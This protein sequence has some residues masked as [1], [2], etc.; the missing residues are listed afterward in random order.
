MNNTEKK[1]SLVFTG[2]STA[3]GFASKTL[4]TENSV[5][6]GPII[7]E[8]IQNS[9]DAGQLT[10]Q[11]QVRV[12]FVFEELATKDLPGIEEY[13]KAFDA[14]LK[15]HEGHIENAQAQISR[16]KKSLQ[17]QTV[18]I[19]NVFDNGIG[20]DTARMNSLLG[21]GTTSKSEQESA[22]S[23]GLGHFTAFPASNL[24]F[25]LYGGVTGNSKRT[26]SAHVILASHKIN[27]DLKGKDGF[28][29]KDTLQTVR[30]R[31]VFPSNGEI[32]AFL[33]SQ[34]DII[35]KD[36]DSGS[37]VVITAFNDF[38]EA[39][40]D[41]CVE[42][43]LSTAAKHFFPSI[44]SGRLVVSVSRKSGTRVLDKSSLGDIISKNIKNTRTGDPLSNSKA[45][46]AYQTLVLSDERVVETSY[47]SVIIHIRQSTQ[48]RTRINLFRSGMWIT[49][50]LPRNRQS[51]YSGYKPFNALV[52]I[53]PP[54]EAF[55]LVRK[56][57]GEKHL[58]ISVKRLTDEDGK[59]FNV[60]FEEIRS[61]IIEGLEKSEAQVYSPADFMLINPVG[62]GVRSSKRKKSYQ[63]DQD[64][65]SIPLV[66]EVDE[67]TSS[68]H[69]SESPGEYQP[70]GGNET[71]TDKNRVP[72]DEPGRTPSF[73]RSG[74]DADVLTVAR[75][76]G[77]RVTLAIRSNED[78]TNA[79]VRLT[80]DNGADASCQKPIQERFIQFKR[81]A[82]VDGY[83]LGE[84]DYRGERGKD[85]ELLI[86]PIMKDQSK[87]VIIPL[88]NAL[89][90]E[91]VIKVNVVSRSK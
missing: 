79:G 65:S 23:Y 29:I 89:S 64:Q 41:S 33:D 77:S 2:F 62:D 69:E 43:I 39:D 52:L 57:E 85:F 70:G 24:Q 5:A 9:L 32:P 17:A 22:G 42:T 46:S 44:R 82:L 78:L 16:I 66:E 50:S 74:R 60:L 26:A 87:T 13:R 81:E 31:Y 30:N 75:S 71:D 48:E 91:A 4:A 61:K 68:L 35:K 67:S 21:D 72:V 45:Y 37:V 8:L 27:G 56:S 55:K 59:N 11:D 14:A 63:N 53:D 40:E 73:N 83:L 34:L 12:S 36:G 58:D 3:E 1:S 28:F 49:D 18:K 51:N 15:T 47:G 10:G 88:L 7:R 80:L 90:E 25:I 86:G 38:L 84:D 6:P 54:S 19:L 20:L 76:E